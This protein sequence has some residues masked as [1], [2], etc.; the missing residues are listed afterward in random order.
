MYATTNAQMPVFQPVRRRRSTMRA[1]RART[2]RILG[3][4]LVVLTVFVFAPKVVHMMGHTEMPA[5]QSYTVEPG[6]TLWDIATQYSGKQDP[7]KVIE[8]IKRANGLVGATVQP[9]QQLTIPHV[10]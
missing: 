6:D 10:R 8:A 3:V 1:R 5:A 7:R 2:L 4:L 9:G